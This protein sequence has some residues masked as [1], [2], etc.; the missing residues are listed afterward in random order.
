MTAFDQPARMDDSDIRRIKLLAA[1]PLLF[2][3]A[4][5]VGQVLTS[6]LISSSPLTL[7]ALN[8]TDPMLLLVAHESSFTGFL[9][10]GTIRLFA[11]DLFLHRLG[12]E[13]GVDAKNYLLGELGEKSFFNRSFQWLE[14]NFPKVGWLMLFLLPGYPMCLLAGIVR[15]KRLPFILV[16]LSG[17]FTRLVLC[18][19]V[20]SIFDGP[21]GKIVNFINRYSLPFTVLMVVLIMF[22][23][24]KNQRRKL[25][26]KDTPDL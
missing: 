1:I 17:T 19:S 20:S 9:I 21:V 16:N 7:L 5:Y 3:V 2:A 15:M 24:A 18:Y 13:Y 14:R 6:T 22:Q 10:I 23:S 25:R 26:N 8:A 4:A 11:P 12:W